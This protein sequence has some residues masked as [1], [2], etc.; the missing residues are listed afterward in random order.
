M[1]HWKSMVDKEFLGAWDLNGKDVHVT[2]DRVEAGEITGEQG[3]KSKKPICWIR[4]AKKPL[5][6]NV[7]NCKI[8]A[9]LYGNDTSDWSGKRIT[10]FAT[11]TS[12]GGQTVECIR[13]RPKAPPAKGEPAQA[14]PA[15]VRE[16]GSDG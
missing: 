9:A 12:F 15:A 5:A 8:I 14:E 4:G 1:P 10:L 6:L 13:V 16:P 11:T 2:I 3:K 7:T